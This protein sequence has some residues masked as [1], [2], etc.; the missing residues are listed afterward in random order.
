MTLL[1]SAETAA[2]LGIK[3]NTLEIWRG[4][5][6]GPDFVKLG[7]AKQCPVRYEP[8]EVTRYLREQSFAST[9]AYSPA[10][11]ST[12]KLQTCGSV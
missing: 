5:G 7:T 8:T 9:S 6:K 3:P 11:N 1:T 4:K 12:V 2:L 10:A